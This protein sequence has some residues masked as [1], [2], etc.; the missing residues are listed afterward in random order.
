MKK[1]MW[2]LLIAILAF[3]ACTGSSRSEP[4][5]NDSTYNNTSDSFKYNPAMPA[6]QNSDDPNRFSQ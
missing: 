6:A 4:I 3:T 2:L 5:A 1:I